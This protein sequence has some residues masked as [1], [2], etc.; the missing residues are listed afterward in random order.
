VTYQQSEAVA[1]L[2]RRV[3]RERLLRGWSAGDLQR[4]LEEV[5][6]SVPKNRLTRLENGTGGGVDLD[7]LMGLRKVFGL[8]SI[9]D[10]LVPVPLLDDREAARLVESIMDSVEALHQAA[11]SVWDGIRQ[12]VGPERHE[13][14]EE[15]RRLAMEKFARAVEE[16]HFVGDP[17]LTRRLQ[18]FVVSLIGGG[19]GE[20]LDR[21]GAPVDWLGPEDQNGRS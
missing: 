9:A 17:G 21:A 15:S 6:C 14:S 3:E 11:E 12:L 8:H 5:G 1:N 4:R 2:A 16:F 20:A 19:V 18:H 10:L 7:L 13:L